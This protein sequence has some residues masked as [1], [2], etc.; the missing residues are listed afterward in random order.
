VKLAFADAATTDSRVYTVTFKR[1]PTSNP[2]GTL[3]D[4][5]SVHIRDGMLF[6]VTFTDK[7]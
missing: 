2:E 5:G 3:V 4:G 6:N 7:S 1:G